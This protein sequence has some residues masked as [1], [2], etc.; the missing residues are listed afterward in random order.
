MATSQ[1]HEN[2]AGPSVA[3]GCRDALRLAQAAA[4]TF[5]KAV[6]LFKDKPVL[7]YSDEPQ[8]IEFD[9]RYEPTSLRLTI[10]RPGGLED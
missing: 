3:V 10:A 8:E 2:E 7:V 5:A 6:P 1:A 9:W 4:A